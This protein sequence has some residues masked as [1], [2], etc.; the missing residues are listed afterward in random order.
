[1]K[2]TDDFNLNKDI[3]NKFKK[4]LNDDVDKIILTILVNLMFTK[5]IK[6]QLGK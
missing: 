6:E 2:R 3:D 4:M 5:N 1:M